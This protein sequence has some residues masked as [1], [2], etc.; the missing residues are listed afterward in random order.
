MSNY[1]LAP[2]TDPTNQVLWESLNSAGIG[3][4]LVDGNASLTVSNE[5]AATWLGIPGGIHTS[6]TPISA[7]EPLKS[8]GLIDKLRAM[9][10]N[11]PGEDTPPCRFHTR[12]VDGTPLCA[13]ARLTSKAPHA[14]RQLLIMLMREPVREI[15]EPPALSG[16]EELQIL[17]SVASAL[18]SS[19]DLDYILKTILTGATASQGL[20][21]NRAFLFLYDNP[22]NSLSGYLAVGPSSPEEAGRIWG[23]LEA[24]RVSLSEL[25]SGQPDDTQVQSG[26]TQGMVASINI[27]LNPDSLIAKACTQK[28]WLNL[29]ALDTV[30]SVTK[31]FS[32]RI[33][34]QKLALVPLVSKG[35]LMGL[36]AADNLIT[37]RPIC[38]DAVQLLQV[39]ADQ[40]A[41]AMERAGLYEEQKER[42][43]EVEKINTLL[44]ESQEHIIKIEKMS[45]IGELT[46]SI[47]HEL[48][49]PLTII[50]GFANLMLK[51]TTIDE[52]KEYLNIIAGE[53]RRAESVLNHVLDF[54]KASRNE[55]TR[56]DFSRLVEKNLALLIGRLRCPAELMRLLAAQSEIWVYGNYDQISHAVYQFLRLVAEEIIPPGKAEITTEVIQERAVMT[57]RLIVDNEHRDGTIKALRQIFTDNKTSQRLTVLVAGEAVRFHGGNF[58]L[59]IGNDRLPSLFVELPLAKE[60]DHVG[61]HYNN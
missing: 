55:S 37:G 44:A 15:S 41:V 56:I 42:T 52:Q 10:S 31:E 57:V 3:L 9:I 61:T 7:I 20:G 13:T 23:N 4:A 2:L 47:A 50:G 8:G 59:S 38:D 28:T 22:T 34:T 16:P 54:S 27:D 32:S 12:S 33:G 14:G 40:A 43:R 19:N 60:A 6:A 21:F 17:S 25:L 58:G 48:R 24:N 35:N 45:V 46:A 29:E 36:L 30:D 18:S 26:S 11:D 5:S 39:F 49:N 53:T 51:S 1:D